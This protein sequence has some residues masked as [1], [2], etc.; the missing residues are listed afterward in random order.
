MVAVAGGKNCEMEKS[1]WLTRKRQSG[2]E[3]LRRRTSYD[4]AQR[5]EGGSAVRRKQLAYVLPAAGRR[6]QQLTRRH[7][8]TRL[9]LAALKDTA[10]LP[11]R[12]EGL[13]A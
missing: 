6:R 7:K 12:R 2:R 3:T 11:N 5:W 13:R 10:A 4:L 8:H 1:S 9:S